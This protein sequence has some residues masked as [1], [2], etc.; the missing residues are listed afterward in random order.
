MKGIIPEC[1][2]DGVHWLHQYE[3]SSS[4]SL[5][6][7]PSEDELDQRRMT[8]R[9]TVMRENH[10]SILHS[11]THSEYA[12]CRSIIEHEDGVESGRRSGDIIAEIEICCKASGISYQSYIPCAHPVPI[13]LL[14]S[15]FL[16]R[17]ERVLLV[18]MGSHPDTTIDSIRL[19]EYSHPT[20]KNTFHSNYHFFILIF[21]CILIRRFETKLKKY[22][23][24][25]I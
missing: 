14:Q 13:R 17:I 7:R 9:M 11:F 2:C 10:P 21:L 16:L 6:S 20:R 19:H 8:R 18:S 23:I 1:T 15:W 4:T 25:S 5:S 12:N 22:Y 3:P 24:L